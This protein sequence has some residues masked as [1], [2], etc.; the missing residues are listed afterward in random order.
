MRL[1]RQTQ[2]E[3]AGIISSQGMKGINEQLRAICRDEAK[4]EKDKEQA[5]VWR[6]SDRIL[7]IN[8]REP[9]RK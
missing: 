9:R 2:M 1:S 6:M 4:R 3:I 5:A 7:A 8:Y